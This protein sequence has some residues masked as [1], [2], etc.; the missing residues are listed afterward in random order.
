LY[1]SGLLGMALIKMIGFLFCG[2][3]LLLC[4]SFME[5]NGYFLKIGYD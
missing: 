2:G 5:L 3:G 4:G 1:L